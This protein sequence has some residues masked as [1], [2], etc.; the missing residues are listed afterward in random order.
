MLQISFNNI[1]L[2]ISVAINLHEVTLNAFSFFL[3][4]ILT[5]KMM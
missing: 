5:V 4:T 1:E 3:S 2:K